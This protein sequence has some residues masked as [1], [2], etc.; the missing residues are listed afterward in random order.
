M[1]WIVVKLVRDNIH[2]IAYAAE[3]RLVTA[4]LGV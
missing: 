1:G 3:T 4:I 2:K